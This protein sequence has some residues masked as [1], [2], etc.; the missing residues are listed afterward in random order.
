M[1]LIEEV[2]KEEDT[3]KKQV[4]FNV[5]QNVIHEYGEE[6]IS[7]LQ[8]NNENESKHEP[9]EKEVNRKNIV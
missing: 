1:F 6:D 8:K 4:T 9:I 7:E 3:K 2:E 5:I